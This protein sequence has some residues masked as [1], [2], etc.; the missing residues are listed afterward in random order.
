ME[1]ALRRNHRLLQQPPTILPRF[2]TR[3][4]P[5]PRA[6]LGQS[7]TTGLLLKDGTLR[8][9]SPEVREALMGFTCGDTE[10]TGLT[11]TQ[12]IH[13]LGQCTDLNLLQWAVALAS[14]TS[15]EGH[16]PR[17]REHP[18]I[19]WEST[20]TLSPPL[21]NLEEAHTLPRGNTPSQQD[22]GGTR[23][24]PHPNLGPR[25]SYQRHG[26]TPMARTSKAT[27]DLGPP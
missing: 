12:R 11:P 18:A 10:A 14:S 15:Q 16:A 13:I 1:N 8:S 23:T 9:P 6:E 22:S 24:P 17:Q 20:Y 27:H 26:S 19:C 3:P 25:G 4:T 21:P 2:R 7:S 5:P